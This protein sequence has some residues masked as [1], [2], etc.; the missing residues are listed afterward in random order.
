[1]AKI[2][3]NYE[4]NEKQKKFHACGATEVVYGGSKGGGKSC[5]LVMESLA[6]GLEHP[7][8][9]IYLF[10]RKYDDLEANIIREWREKVPKELYKYNEQKHMATL[11]NGTNVFF[12]YVKNKI[13]ANDEYQ[14]RSMDFCGIDELT[15]HDEETVQVLLSCLRSAKG[16]PVRFRGTCN[17]GGLGHTW[18]KKKYIMG[19]D[20]GAKQIK[21]P[22]SGNSIAFIPATIYDNTILMTNDPAYV[23]RLENLPS[24]RRAAFLYGDWDAFDGMAFEE[25]S[26]DIHVCRPFP[27][28][29]HW[30]RWRSADNG[31]TDPFA[32]YWFAVDEQGKIYIYREYTR[33]YDDPKVTY[34]D[35][36]RKVVEMSTYFDLQTNS[37]QEEAYSFTVVG[38]DAFNTHPLAE[39]GKTIEDYYIEGG[40][41]SCIRA[42]T[43]RKLRKATYHEYLKPF[44]DENT[45]KMTA[46]LQI[47]ATCTKLIE[48]LPLQQV[49]DDDPE[50]VAETDIDHWYDAAGYGI[51]AHHAAKTRAL[52]QQKS[53]VQLHRERL[54][55]QKKVRRIM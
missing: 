2:V 38:H 26:Y 9:V 18:V 6:Y 37:E 14:G 17:P 32:W 21:C 31:Y 4:P 10:R 5:A 22:I 7:G 28:P 35:Q 46:K 49:D 13:E 29:A 19:T 43:D 45:G 1:M 50:K 52:P 12:R 44:E 30:K 54:A 47:F 15:Q 27:I 41:N 36:A 3:I 23:K 48:T 42:I 8:A 39:Q 16:F 34:S 11:T 51:I 33:E 20:H 40:V 53:A 55:K 25:W 24:G